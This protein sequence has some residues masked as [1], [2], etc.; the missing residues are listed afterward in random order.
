MEKFDRVGTAKG[1]GGEGGGKGDDAV[2][3]LQCFHLSGKRSERGLGRGAEREE[4][5][6]KK[7]LFQLLL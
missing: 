2:G 3:E 7:S 4:A 6:N 1:G 5:G